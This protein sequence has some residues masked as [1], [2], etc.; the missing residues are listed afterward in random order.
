[1]AEV[2]SIIE[3]TETIETITNICSEALLQPSN[4]P[5]KKAN[6]ILAPPRDWKMQI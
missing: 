4:I 1:M 3:S 5:T 6:V 2:E